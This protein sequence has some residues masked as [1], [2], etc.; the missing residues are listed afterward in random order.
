VDH[1][2]FV[3]QGHG[4]AALRAG[5]VVEDHHGGAV[6]VNVNVNVNVNVTAIRVLGPWVSVTHAGDGS[7]RD[8]RRAPGRTTDPDLGGRNGAG[9]GSLSY[10]ALRAV[11]VGSGTPNGGSPMTFLIILV[12]VWVLAGFAG[13]VAG[14]RGMVTGCGWYLFIFIVT[15][16]LGLGTFTLGAI[17]GANLRRREKQRDRQLFGGTVNLGAGAPEMGWPR[18]GPTV[19][20]PADAFGAAPTTPMGAPPSWHPPAPGTGGLGA[21]GPGSGSAWTASSPHTLVP[22]GWHIDGGDPLVQRYWDGTRWT[23]RVRWTGTAWQP[24]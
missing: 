16:F 24:F 19:P 22:P 23:Q 1:P 3:E 5:V 21:G 10:S 7:K 6:T 14:S 20:S 4:G 11:G 15:G 12:A 9:S 17:I 8:N 13:Y 18:P 2:P